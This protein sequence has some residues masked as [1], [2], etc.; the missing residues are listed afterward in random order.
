MIPECIRE[1]TM[2]SWCMH[3]I[4]CD[5]LRQKPE[6]LQL[7][8]DWLHE[9][10]DKADTCDLHLRMQWEKAAAAGLDAFIALALRK[11]EAGDTLRSSS[12]FCAFWHGLE[13]WNF[14]KRWKVLRKS[15][16][17]LEETAESIVAEWALQ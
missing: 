10:H 13:S 7:A 17:T 2:Q 5:R 8:I 14:R 4:W 15:G 1:K 11:D 3:K 12:P 9:F 6:L 16:L